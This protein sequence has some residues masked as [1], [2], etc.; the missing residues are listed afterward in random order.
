MHTLRRVHERMSGR[1]HFRESDE[2][3]KKLRLTAMASCAG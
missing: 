1:N 3:K 2:V